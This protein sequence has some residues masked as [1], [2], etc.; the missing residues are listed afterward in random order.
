MFHFKTPKQN[1]SR[2][3]IKPE[4]NKMEATAETVAV[5]MTNAATDKDPM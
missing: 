3:N 2:V 5:E 4:A 1:Q